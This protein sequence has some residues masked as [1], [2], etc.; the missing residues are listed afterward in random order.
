[1]RHYYIIC[2]EGLNGRVLAEYLHT[3]KKFIFHHYVKGVIPY[4]LLAITRISKSQYKELKG[5]E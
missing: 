3:T 2:C 4:K 1:M 5:N